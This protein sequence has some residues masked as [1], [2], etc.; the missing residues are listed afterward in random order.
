MAETE[1]LLIRAWTHSESDLDRIFDAYS[2][3]EVI[4]YLG[5]VPEADVLARPGPGRGRP[6]GRPVYAPTAAS[7]SGPRR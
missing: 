6:V 4:Q 7:A 3:M 2:R 1:R 5:F